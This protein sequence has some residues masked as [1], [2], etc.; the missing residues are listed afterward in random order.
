MEEGENWVSNQK[1]GKIDAI[2]AEETF[3]QHR[4]TKFLKSLTLS[5][6]LVFLSRL[7]LRSEAAKL[8]EK[9]EYLSLRDLSFVG[10]D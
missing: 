8:S 10:R 9:L 3:K 1:V 5:F 7:L 4:L 2:S 6:D